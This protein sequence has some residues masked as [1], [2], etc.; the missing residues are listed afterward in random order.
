MDCV[1][2]YDD[3]DISEVR[4]LVENYAI[5]KD[6]KDSGI[7]KVTFLLELGSETA[8]DVFLTPKSDY[9]G[10]VFVAEAEKNANLAVKQSDGRYLVQI[11]N[12][13]ANKLGDTYTLKVRAGGEFDVKVSALSYVH[14][15]LNGSANTKL[16]KAV[17]ALYDYY[18]ATMEYINR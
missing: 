8:I 7:E 18:V 6:T 17:V 10:T 1:N 3:D 13:S 4:G 16:H 12:I 9:N 15:A 14:A 11:P 5:V 2:I